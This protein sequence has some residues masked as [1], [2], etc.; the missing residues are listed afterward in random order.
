[1]YGEVRFMAEAYGFWGL[2][3]EIIAVSQSSAARRIGG[4]TVEGGW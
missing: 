1:M 3:K 4:G 2:L